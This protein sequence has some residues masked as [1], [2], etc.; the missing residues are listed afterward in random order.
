MKDICIIL[1]LLAI[2][3]NEDFAPHIP[4]QL[5]FNPSFPNHRIL[6][7]YAL[8]IEQIIMKLLNQPSLLAFRIE[9]VMEAL[10]DECTPEECAYA[11]HLLMDNFSLIMRYLYSSTT[12][13]LHVSSVKD[14]SPISSAVS[15]PSLVPSPCDPFQQ[16]V[17]FDVVIN[18]EIP[19][20]VGMV[21]RS[22]I[23]KVR[24]LQLCEL[25]LDV[26]PSL[27]SPFIISHEFNTLL[28]VLLF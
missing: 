10:D 18:S 8:H 2:L 21:R 27:F 25:L 6:D 3:L 4:S 15:S 28:I 13:V 11:I 19:S 23:V 5:L 9:C 16:D 12:S 20:T 24:L 7:L 14:I 22:G 17:E 26:E 1:Q